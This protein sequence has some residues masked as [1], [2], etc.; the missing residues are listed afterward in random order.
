MNHADDRLADAPSVPPTSDA[1]ASPDRPCPTCGAMGHAVST[2]TVLAHLHS[3]AISKYQPGRQHHSCPNQTCRTV[4]HAP[5]QMFTI[6]DVAARVY[7]KEAGPD[8][9]VCPC[10]RHTREYL[11]QHGWKVLCELEARIA[12]G[13]CWCDLS[14]VSGQPCLEAVRLELLLH[15]PSRQVVLDNPS[16]QATAEESNDA[17]PD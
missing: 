4:C 2:T 6:E 9:N 17:K 14:N 10:Y 5:L 8:V 7:G 16:Q 3:R 12:R 11:K 15:L 1:N 13:A